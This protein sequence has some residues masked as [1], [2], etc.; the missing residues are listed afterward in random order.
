VGEEAGRVSHVPIDGEGHL[1]V[2]EQGPGVAQ[3]HR[4][5]IE[6]DHAGGRVDAVGDLVH[7][8]RGGQAR[9]D[10][11]QLPEAGLAD[12]VA[13]HA[14]EQVALGAHAHLDGGQLGDDLIGDGPVGGEVV[15][16]AEQ[17]VVHPGDV[18]ARGVEYWI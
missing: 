7:V 5:V 11:E 3:D 9:G 4:V 12:Q 14:A 15:L 2:G 10:V 1:V 8:L 17:V 13:D 6:V 18:R 16:A